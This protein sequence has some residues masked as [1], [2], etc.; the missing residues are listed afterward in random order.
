QELR[1]DSDGSQW[2]LK[3][4]RDG[5]GES[6]EVFVGGCEC[7][8]SGF[9][10]RPCGSLAF[11]Q[12]VA[13]DFANAAFGDIDVRA[14]GSDRFAGCVLEHTA[15]GFDPAN[16]SIREDDA[17]LVNHLRAMLHDGFGD[18]VPH[19]LDVFGMDAVDKRLS[20]SFDLAGAKTVEASE[21][22]CPFE[23]V[24]CKDPF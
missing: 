19:A 23:A 17:E 2:L 16:G 7:G 20:G 8:A 13:F 24:L 6:L 10:I 18:F 22:R 12:R 4:M 5:V 9:G 1:V 3:V 11:D 15:A 21:C 14:K